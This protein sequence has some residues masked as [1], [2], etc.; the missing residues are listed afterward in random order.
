M[1]VYFDAKDLIGVF[2]HGKPYNADRF[3]RVFRDGKHQLVLSFSNI[4]EVSA[5]LLSRNATTNVM[6]LLNR[7]EELPVRF[8]CEGTLPRD[9][10]KAALTAFSTRREYQG[11]F[12]FVDRYD[13]TFA[14]KPL[15][16][17]LYLHHS[18]AETV[19]TVWTENAQALRQPLLHA[20][21]LRN[22][23]AADR[24]LKNSKSVAYNFVDAVD[25]HLA[26]WRLLPPADGLRT[27]ARWIYSKPSR[28]PSLRLKYEVYHAILRNLGDIPKDSDISDFAHLGC[29]PYID[30]I[31]L[32]LRM[33]AYTHQVISKL[34]LPYERQICKNAQEVLGRLLP[35]P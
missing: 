18:I 8:I 25:R 26:Q 20:E 9:E 15:L 19:F 12:P 24:A 33:Y 13:E 21:L 29:T 3:E 5:P 16:S 22:L 11:V 35:K 6:R 4:R 7:I 17:R 34:G 2:E 1:L 27:F 32:D 10:L 31:T 23:F 14:L 30:L 28:C